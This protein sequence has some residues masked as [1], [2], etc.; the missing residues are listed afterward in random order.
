[1]A[2]KK[3]MKLRSWGTL[4]RLP[5]GRYQASYVGPDLAR[6]T[7]PVTY[8]GRGDAEYWLEIERRLIERDEWTAPAVRAAA[9][10]SRGIS[11]ADYLTRWIDQRA[12]LSHSTA[13]AYRNNVRVHIAPKPLGG[14]PL[15]AVTPDAVRSWYA[16]MD[17]SKP[18]ARTAAYS[19]LRTALGTAISDGIF[20][21]NPGVIAGASAQSTK[22]RAVILTPAEISE[23]AN[24]VPERLRAWALIA[25][26]CGLRIGEALELRRG[27]ISDDYTVIHVSRGHRHVGGKCE[28]R[29]TKSGR[30]RDVPI[31]PHI[32]ED[33]RHHIRM[34][35]GIGPNALLFAPTNGKC[36][37]SRDIVNSAIQP[38]LGRIGKRGA[39]IHD[40]RH[41][42]GVLLALS[43]ATLAEIMLILGHS[44]VR[45][46][47]I[48]QQVASGR[49]AEVA[50][51]LS[52]LAEM[53]A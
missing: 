24:G 6:H 42:C 19:M 7:A 38:V 37:L 35:V 18:T 3:G 1:M 9:T 10:K 14:L 20:T 34:H 25:N 13:Y 46:A 51:G 27:D 29:S 2:G 45:A 28:I 40:A 17:A 39:V 33:I 8:T 4:R 32:R 52:K 53:A 49:P 30:S 16:T 48:Y 15:S 50:A 41:T 12:N 21:R 31:P 43:G 22:R 44:T 23:L 26:Y 11:V 36:H 47:M 5:S